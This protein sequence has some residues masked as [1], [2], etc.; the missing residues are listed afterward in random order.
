MLFM[1][2]ETA[3][4]GLITYDW[5]WTGSGFTGNN[6]EGIMSYDD[7]LDGTG[8]ITAGDIAEFSIEGFT[9]TTSVFTW[10]LS[11]GTQ[12]NPFQLSFD[13]TLG[14]FVFGGLY[15]TALDSV[16]WGDDSLAALI[17]GNGSCGFV[18]SGL[19]FDSRSVSDKTQF[20]FTLAESPSSTPE[21]TTL[22]LMSLGL[23]GLGF[24]R[25]KRL[26]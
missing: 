5:T 11:T 26:Q 17:C 12:G 3:N 24:S 2:C 20:V 25:R 1:F 16:V 6:A 13:T 4:A 14:A 18:G 21:P 23:I 22:V 8:I 19:F 10:D 7:T 9:G 15:P